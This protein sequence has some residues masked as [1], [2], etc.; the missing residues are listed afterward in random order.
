MIWGVAYAREDF[1]GDDDLKKKKVLSIVGQNLLFKGGLLWF[2]PIPYL[3]PIMPKY[4][5][6]KKRY[7]DVMTLPEQ[8]REKLI[9]DIISA[10][11]TFRSWLGTR[12]RANLCD[13]TRRFRYHLCQVYHSNY[14]AGFEL[15]SKQHQR[16]INCIMD[17]TLS[18]KLSEEIK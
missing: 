11:C 14:R 18:T 6:L 1:E 8:G 10:W 17:T 3:T 7:D 12:S 13:G 5:K 9:A 15:N 16:R 2:E 4:K